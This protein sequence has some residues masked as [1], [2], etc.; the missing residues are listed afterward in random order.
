MPIHYHIARDR[1]SRDD[2]AMIVPIYV[3]G[4]PWRCA[5]DGEENNDDWARCKF[6]NQER[7]AWICDCGRKNGKGD[8]EC[9][10]CGNPRPDPE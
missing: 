8:D 5:I 7:G 10:E 9:S 1:S 3:A 2:D 6:C 4:E